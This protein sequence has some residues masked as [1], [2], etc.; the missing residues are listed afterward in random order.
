MAEQAV[1]KSATPYI[2][3]NPESDFQRFKDTLRRVVSVPKD[4]VDKAIA[5]E[6]EQKK[7]LKDNPENAA[8]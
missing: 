2:S 8:L 1:V 6:A 5:E 4:A 7:R 3:E